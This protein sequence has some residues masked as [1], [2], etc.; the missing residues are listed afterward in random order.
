[1]KKKKVFQAA[2]CFFFFLEEDVTVVMDGIDIGYLGFNHKHEE[3]VIY[4]S[5]APWGSKST[6]PRKFGN[7]VTV[8]RPPVPLCE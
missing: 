5:G 6:H 7:H 1:M 3:L 4:I 8:H 2:G